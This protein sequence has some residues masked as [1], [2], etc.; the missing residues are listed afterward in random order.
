MGCSHPLVPSLPRAL[1]FWVTSTRG[2]GASGFGADPR[3]CIFWNLGFTGI[4]PLS[5]TLPRAPA[6]GRCSSPARGHQRGTE[7]HLPAAG[8]GPGCASGTGKHR[9]P[10]A[11]GSPPCPTRRGQGEEEEGEEEEEEARFRAGR[12]EIT[13]GGCRGPV[14]SSPA[15]SHLPRLPTVRVRVCAPARARFA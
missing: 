3:P 7:R 14:L 2:A 6:R 15:P 12:S 8:T 5:F 11:A 4:F 9:E 1:T 13:A 10:G